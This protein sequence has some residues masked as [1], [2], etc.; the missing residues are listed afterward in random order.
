MFLKAV[1]NS[2]KQRNGFNLSPLFFFFYFFFRF[3]IANIYISLVLL[4]IIRYIEFTE[5][6]ILYVWYRI[7]PVQNIQFYPILKYDKKG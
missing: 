5:R 1:T 7:F 2:I 6:Q 3:V 4:E